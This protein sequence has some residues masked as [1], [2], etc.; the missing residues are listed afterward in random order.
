[1][2]RKQI[3]AIK[4]AKDFRNKINGKYR[5]LKMILFGS[6]VTG[7]TREGSDIDLLIVSDKFRKKSVFMSELLKEWHISQKRAAPVDFLCY[8]PEEFAKLSK[9]ISIVKQALEEGIEV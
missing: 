1:M 3:E 6:Q 7:K 9:E 8:S 2:G 4:T 5:I